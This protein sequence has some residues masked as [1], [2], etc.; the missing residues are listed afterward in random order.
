MKEKVGGNLNEP[1][2]L[3]SPRV[4]HPGASASQVSKIRSKPPTRPGYHSHARIQ[5]KNFC[6][7]WMDGFIVRNLPGSLDNQE[8]LPV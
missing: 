4:V 7:F 2:G 3:A 1:D 5:T 8:V 6:S